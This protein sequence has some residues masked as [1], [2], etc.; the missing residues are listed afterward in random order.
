MDATQL[1]KE[2][3][4]RTTAKSRTIKINKPG[5]AAAALKATKEEPKDGRQLPWTYGEKRKR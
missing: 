5:G 2:A 3:A 4:R 1:G